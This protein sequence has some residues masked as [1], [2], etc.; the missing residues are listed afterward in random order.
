MSNQNLPDI[1]S[2]SD[3]ELLFLSNNAAKESHKLQTTLEETKA[4][5]ENTEVLQVALRG[6]VAEYNLLQDEVVCR[7]LSSK[8]AGTVTL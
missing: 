8:T 6:M 4:A 7:D 2:L 1:K 3:E 5:D